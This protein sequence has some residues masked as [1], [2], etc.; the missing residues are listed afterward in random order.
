MVW[1]DSLII[2][3]VFIDSVVIGKVYIDTIVVSDGHLDRRAIFKVRHVISHDT[4]PDL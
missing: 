3:K 1:F 4:K 2:G